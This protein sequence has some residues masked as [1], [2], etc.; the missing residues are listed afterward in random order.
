MLERDCIDVY[1]CHYLVYPLHVIPQLLQVLDVSVTDLA[2]DEVSLA[3]SLTRLARL[4]DR[5]GPRTGAR[6]LAA[7]PP[8]VVTPRQRGYRDTRRAPALPGVLLTQAL[9]NIKVRE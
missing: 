3:L 8:G 7:R 1:I 2:D 6:L 5:P 4:H 9:R